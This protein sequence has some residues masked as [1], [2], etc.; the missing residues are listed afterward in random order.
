[1]GRFRPWKQSGCCSLFGGRAAGS[2]R[3]DPI[4]RGVLT[5]KHRLRGH[6]HT[7]LPGSAVVVRRAALRGGWLA[8]SASLLVFGLLPILLMVSLLRQ[9]GFGWDFR[10]FYLGAQAY[11]HGVS[12]YPSQSLAALASKQGFV[13]PAPMAA[14]F[15]PFAVLPYTLA[16]AAWVALSVGAIAA[17]LWLVGVRDWRCLGALFLTHPV[18]Q[19]VR[20]GT[21]MPILTLLLALLWK[22]RERV[23]TA[24]VLAAVLAVSKVFLFPLILWLVVTRRVKTAALAI[25]IAASVCVLGW[26]PIHLASISSYP[27]LLR[28]LAGFEQTFSYSLTSLAVGMGVSAATAG[29][30]AVAAAA[31]LLAWAAW[32][33]NNDLLA[34]RLAL[35][36]SF[37]LSP[38]IWGHYYVLL[39]VPLAL[40][41]PRLSPLWLAAIWIKPDTLQMRDSTVWVALA[42]LVLFMQLDL[43]PLLS[44]RWSRQPWPRMRQA[45]AVAGLAGILASTAVAAEAGQTGTTALHPASRTAQASGVASIRLDRSTRQLCW[46]IWTDDF[47]PTRAA[48]TIRTLAAA[49]TAKPLT[50]YTGIG[51]DGQSQGCARLNRNHP[52]LARALPVRANRYLLSLTAP[53]G[54][55]LTG[56][57]QLANPSLRPLERVERTDVRAAFDTDK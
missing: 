20:L 27:G 48:L 38:I 52:A 44:R 55:F 12:P 50:G 30:L 33:R 17:A 10:A 23:W 18:E 24:G 19:S 57:L 14:L 31:G 1:M 2:R 36:A 35:A 43:A 15:A 26:L 51:S 28:A 46:R 8:Q 39:V 29:L 4:S 5:E 54:A 16:L 34:F 6:L 49:A 3:L 11:L 7:L 25:A 32:A 53:N 37:V 42:L 22:Y 40:S 41:R 21:L 56:D 45:I 9:Q 47:P 13:Y